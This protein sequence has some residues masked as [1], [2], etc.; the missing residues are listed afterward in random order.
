MGGSVPGV[1]SFPPGSHSPPRTGSSPSPGSLFDK[2]RA[3]S[4]ASRGTR[5]SD[6]ARALLGGPNWC[7]TPTS[8]LER[9]W[10]VI[11]PQRRQCACRGHGLCERQSGVVTP[12]RGGPSPECHPLDTAGGTRAG[13]P[14]APV[15]TFG[16]HRG[17]CTTCRW[18]LSPPRARTLGG[19][20]SVLSSSVAG[21]GV[22]AGGV[23]RAG[24]VA[25]YGR[26]AGRGAG[27][28]RCWCGRGGGSGAGAGFLGRVL[29]QAKDTDSRPSACDVNTGSFRPQDPRLPA[30]ARPWDTHGREPWPSLLPADRAR[31]SR[32]RGTP[33]LVFPRIS[34]APAKAA[35][36]PGP[37][38]WPRPSGH[39]AAHSPLGSGPLSPAP[40]T[41]SHTGCPPAS[42]ARSFSFPRQPPLWPAP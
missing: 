20:W 17:L 27:P 16:L 32:P 2:L 25:P 28:L 14:G 21:L 6:G 18:G 24:A 22:G 37:R 15:S 9:K 42:P 13:P 40:T 5:V 36:W 23:R 11:S 29:G 41:P 35:A 8:P 10:G 7:D 1:H 39:S 33:S 30:P 38:F 34:S 3:S 26:T 19:R 31:P 4:P 12:A